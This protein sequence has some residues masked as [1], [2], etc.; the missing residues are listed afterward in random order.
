MLGLLLHLAMRNSETLN[1]VT[2]QLI[3]VPTIV[4]EVVTEE[5][6]VGKTKEAVVVV[7]QEVVHNLLIFFY[8]PCLL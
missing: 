2:L 6:E 8:L 1:M 3:K 4:I 7:N 5:V